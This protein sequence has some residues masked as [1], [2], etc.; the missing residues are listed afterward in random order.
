M[1]KEESGFRTQAWLT[2]AMK[3]GVMGLL[4]A[5]ALPGRGA[6]Q[7]AVKSRVEPVY[8]E[9]AKRMRITG[10]V[11]VE[12]TVDAEGKVT[13]VKA[14]SG[15]SAL[16]NA[17]EIA[18]RKWKFAPGDGVSLVDVTVNFEMSE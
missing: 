10:V 9:L 18:V 2:R 12:A 7:R 14:L 5:L 13:D 3:A 6:D 11:K 1:I 15:N 4:L 17:A 16:V 8:P